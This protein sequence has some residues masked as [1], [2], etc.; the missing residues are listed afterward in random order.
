VTLVL[1]TDLLPEPDRADALH[2]S[3]AEQQPARGVV[4]DRHRVRH[5]VEHVALGPEVSVLRTGGSPLQIVRT[6]RQARADASEFLALGLRRRGAGLISTGGTD[7]PLPVGHLNCVDMTA[8]Y[9]L[10]HTTENVH[11]VLVLS[12]RAVG[13][14][15][16]AVRAAAPTLRRSPVRDLVQRHVAE[17]FSSGSALPP[18]L[19]QVTGQ[20]TTA[21]VRALITTAGGHREARGAMHDALATRITMYLEAHLDDEALAVD[22]VAAAHHISV[23]HLYDVW[24]GA[25]HDETPARWIMSRRLLR[26]RQ[27]L[28]L[29]D[30]SRS[31]VAMIARRCGFA[32]SSHFARR[33]RASFGVSPTEWR[34]ARRADR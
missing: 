11:D 18:E 31:S 4:V 2:A 32:D 30:P 7:T 24:A 19:G 10:V 8:P 14:S 3:Y 20:A 29:S 23:R 17:L 16:D 26:A 28:A 34:D 12:L 1:D 27:Q 5:R 15:V 21:L 13:V 22:Q 9:R 33:F 6:P 25:G